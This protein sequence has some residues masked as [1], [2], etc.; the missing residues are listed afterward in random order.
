MEDK[1]VESFLLKEAERQN[2]GIELIASENYPSSSVREA[3]GSIFTAKYA[4]G[5]PGHRYYGGCVNVDAVE[6]LAIERAKKLFQVPYANVQPHSG[7]QANAAAYHAL[8]PEGGKILSLTLNDGG[9]LT[10][11]SPVSFSSH[12][13]DFVF[14]SLNDEGKLDYDSIG[15]LLAEEKPDLL[16]AGY[17]SYHFAIDF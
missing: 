10:H 6:N 1:I 11:G 7:S 12:D 15:E 14:Y 17:S 13:Y 3:Q 8:L 9:H 4:E 5:Y 16:L 2:E